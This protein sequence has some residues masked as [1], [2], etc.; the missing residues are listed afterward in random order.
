MK[1][2]AMEHVSVNGTEIPAASIAGEAQNHPADGPQAAW[3]AAAEALVVKTLLIEEARR[4]GIVAKAL[5]DSR[6]R[7]LA[8]DDAL[9]EALLDQEVIT[10]RADEET[11]RRYYDRHKD[12]FASPD[13][14]EA[15]HILFSAHAEDKDAYARAVTNATDTIVELQMHPERFE[16]LAVAHSACPSAKQGG[17]L[18]QLGPGQTVSEFETFLFNLEPGQLCPVP[19]KTRYGVHVLRIGRKIAG[20]VRPFEAV[21]DNIAGYLEEASWRRAVSQYIGILA[22]RANIEGVTLSGTQS[23][24]VQ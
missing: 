14:V 4:L 3:D 16:A 8:E 24:L 13:L 15:S 19:V 22:G 9:I 10:P 2:R 11:C 20:S 21:R 23:P 1:G 6:G 17:N 18:G 7:A 5:F 12:R